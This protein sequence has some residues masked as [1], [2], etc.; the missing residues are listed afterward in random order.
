MI[1]RLDEAGLEAFLDYCRRHR[2]GLDKSYLSDAELEKFRIEPSNPTFIALD[3]DMKIAGA[4]SLVI[5]EAAIISKRARL[6]ILHSETGDPGNYKALIDSLIRET[7]GIDSIYIF[8]PDANLSLL[9]NL[10]GLGFKIDRF[11]FLLIREDGLEPEARMPAGFSIRRFA[12][13]SDEQAWCDIR[14]SAFSSLKG[15]ESPITAGMVREMVAGE[16][17]IDGGMLFLLNGKK[18]VGLIRGSKD[19]YE[20]RTV[21]NIGPLAVLPSYQGKGLGRALLRAMLV[22]AHEQ[23]YGCTTLSVNADNESA[24]SLYIHEGFKKEEGF[25]CLSMTVQNP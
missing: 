20:G 18:P 2:D 1:R 15:N 11:V 4:A 22:F 12:A 24:L 13:G 8:S 19:E 9:S 17:H 6:R 14:N 7:S 10:N 23:S 21:M 5:D 16:D 3:G 25:A